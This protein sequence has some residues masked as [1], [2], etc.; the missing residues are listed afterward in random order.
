MLCYYNQFNSFT[1]LLFT[2]SNS[3]L[4]YYYF[5]FLDRYQQAVTHMWM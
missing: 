3:N 1:T 5:E 4:I 2:I